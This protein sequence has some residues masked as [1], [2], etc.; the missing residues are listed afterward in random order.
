M[1]KVWCSSG[2]TLNRRRRLVAHAD[3]ST[4]AKYLHVSMRMIQALRSP[5]DALTLKPLAPSAESG[6]E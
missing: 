2:N 6:E 1:L 3:I 5:F 4:S